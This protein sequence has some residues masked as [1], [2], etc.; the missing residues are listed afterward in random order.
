MAELFFSRCNTPGSLGGT[1]CT[2]P[3]LSSDSTWTNIK[4]LGELVNSSGWDSH[5][6]YPIAVMHCIS[7]PNGIGE[8]WT[9]K[10]ILHH[11]ARPEVEQGSLNAG[12][13]INTVNMQ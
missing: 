6:L 13:V 11:P 10:H 3:K 7:H 4:N 8:F 9:V 5:P 2:S 1:I 12:P